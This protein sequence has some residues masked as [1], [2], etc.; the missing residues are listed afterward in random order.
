MIT[1]MQAP[2]PGAALLSCYAHTRTFS[3]STCVGRSTLTLAFSSST[4]PSSAA[5]DF[6]EAAPTLLKDRFPFVN[7]TGFRNTTDSKEQSAMILSIE[8][9]IDKLEH[10]LVRS[11]EEIY[12]SEPYA[13]AMWDAE[14]KLVSLQEETRR[15]Q[16]FLDSKEKIL[17]GVLHEATVLRTYLQDAEAQASSLQLFKESH[18]A[19][20]AEESSRLERLSSESLEILDNH[21]TVNEAMSESMEK[22]EKV[23]ESI[24]RMYNFSASS[25]LIEVL[26]REASLYFQALLMLT[27]EK[28]LDIKRLHPELARV[29]Q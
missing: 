26:Q 27:E 12:G 23:W 14:F 11:E 28:N 6:K 13:D 10:V 3:A 22:V 21:L 2:Y 9:D 15:L 5:D 4:S 8:K 24:V 20:Q 1:A 29:N 17:K 18:D 7:E 16:T 19:K 25:K